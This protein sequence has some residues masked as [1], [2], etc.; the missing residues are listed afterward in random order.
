MQT[1]FTPEQLRQPDIA[2]ANAEL[3]KCVHCGFCMATCP[4]Y[5]ISGDELEA[6][7]GRIY[8]IKTLLEENDA[9]PS[10]EVLAHL[11]RCLTCLSCTTTCPSGVGYDRL[12]AIARARTARAGSRPPLR[13]LAR[14]L[15]LATVPEPARLRPLANLG[16]LTAPLA[17]PLL[18]ARWPPCWTWPGGAGRGAPCSATIRR[19]PTGRAGA[20]APHC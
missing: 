7:R 17:L 2:A 16:R 11:D 19:S 3:R 13:R 20:A 15:L 12:I 14:K 5:L 10:W 4:T 8:A 1:N 18:K 6:P 9:E